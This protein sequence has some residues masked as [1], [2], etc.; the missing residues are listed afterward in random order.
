MA[1]ETER[2]CQ[3]LAN[4]GESLWFPALTGTLVDA[5]K[6][7]PASN[8]VPSCDGYTTT[9]YLLGSGAEPERI[10]VI[11][12]DEKSAGPKLRVECL[13]S[14][15]VAKLAHTGL[16]FPPPDSSPLLAAVRV[17]SR[18]CAL[19]AIEPTLSRS[20]EQLVHSLHVLSVDDPAY[21]VSFSDPDI[22]F[23]I[24]VSVPLHG[25]VCAARTAEAIIH[26]AMHL[27]LTLIERLVPLAEE[28]APR[29]YSPWK[30]EERPISGLIHAMFVFAVID[31]WLSKLASYPALSA[32]VR[33][34]REQIRAEFDSID[35]VACLHGTTS[36]GRMFLQSVIKPFAH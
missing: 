13:S 2:I 23:S 12:A 29:Q 27:Q 1:D 34:R 7:V 8:S 32:H 15:A 22:P 6:M 3:S 31:Q 19:I 18:A 17:I 5:R 10:I 4:P 11:E 26:E 21:D 36:A 16:L 30:R 35:L 24:F 20:V 25:P 33:C 28:T 9:G 14:A